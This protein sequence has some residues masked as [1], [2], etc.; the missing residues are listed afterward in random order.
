MKHIIKLSSNTD[1]RTQN[2]LNQDQIGSLPEW[3]LSDLYNS[4]SDRAIKRDLKEVKKLSCAFAL[5][6]ENKLSELSASE[7]LECLQAQEKI[8]GLQGRLL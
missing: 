2:A 8:D 7:M 1:D 6:Y 3:D 5:R 4:P